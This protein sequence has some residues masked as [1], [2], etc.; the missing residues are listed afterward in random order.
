MISDATRQ[1]FARAEEMLK[2]KGHEVTNPASTECQYLLRLSMGWEES[3]TGKEVEFYGFALMTDIVSI[4]KDCDAVYFLKDWRQSR[5]AT[6][7]LYFAKAVGKRM[8]FEDRQQA[9]E[10]LIERMYRE[11]EAGN[12]PI[13]YDT[14]QNR[15]DI[16]IAYFKKHLHEA[17]LPIEEKSTKHESQ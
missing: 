13:E 16:E 2:A 5:G 11:A 15:N 6:A 17:W 14:L 9:C 1:K 8:Y 12:T 4:W 3:K 10:Y 7:E